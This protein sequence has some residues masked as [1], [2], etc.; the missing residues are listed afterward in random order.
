MTE[1]ERQEYWVSRASEAQEML[2]PAQR[3]AIERAQ[4]ALVL[5]AAEWSEDYDLKSGTV[6]QLNQAMKSLCGNFDLDHGTF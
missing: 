5:F 3:N 6:R 2:T 4:N 1:E